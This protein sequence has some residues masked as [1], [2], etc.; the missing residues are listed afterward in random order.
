MGEEALESGSDKEAT[1][2]GSS[3][4]IRA[5]PSHHTRTC[6]SAGKAAGAIGLTAVRV[7]QEPRL[8]S[9]WNEAKAINNEAGAR[10]L[11]MGRNSGQGAGHRLPAPASSRQPSAIIASFL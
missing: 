8:G 10:Y 9:R 11:F 7:S 3:Q 6:V 4:G 5:G 2:R 1:W